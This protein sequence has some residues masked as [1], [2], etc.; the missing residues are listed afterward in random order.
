MAVGWA[1]EWLPPT[2]YPL[3]PV[4]A[5]TVAWEAAALTA[6]VDALQFGV[7]WLTHRC[8]LRSHARHH[9]HTAPRVEDAF[10]TGPADALL[11][12]VLPIYAA[13]WLW[14]PT[15]LGTR[16]WGVKAPCKPLLSNPRGKA[17]FAIRASSR[18][19]SEFY[20]LSPQ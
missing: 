7:H 15:R 3:R 9:V 14:R 4:P 20:F 19:A 13:L 8:R 5:S 2:V 16:A 11:Q 18:D 12:L 10:R 1:L 6:T 17:E